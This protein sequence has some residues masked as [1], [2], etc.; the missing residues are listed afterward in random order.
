[1]EGPLKT[2]FFLLALCM[3]GCPGDATQRAASAGDAKAQFELSLRL[4]GANP[5]E[6]SRLLL[7]A[8][9]KGNSAA[10]FHLGKQL[11]SGK[12]RSGSPEKG[13][14]WIQKSARS[15]FL[16]AQQFLPI[17]HLRAL[18]TRR[19][20]IEAVKELRLPLGEIDAPACVELAQTMEMGKGGPLLIALLQK[21][22]DQGST[23]CGFMLAKHL[24][25][26]PE[27]G[28]ENGR[29]RELLEKASAARHPQAMAMLGYRMLNGV[30]MPPKPNK[31]IDLLSQ[32]AE[33]GNHDAS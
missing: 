21:G 1:M 26:S 6:A 30:G 19:D 5:A 33:L 15:G 10:Q 29:I 4:E 14:F 17:C 27:A 22:L 20:P 2:S 3:A 24:S 12:N 25:L 31:G 23:E 32:A 18:G 7:L 11:L 9:G 8:A 16:P 28:K 13:F